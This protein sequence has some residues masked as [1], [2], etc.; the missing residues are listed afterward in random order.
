MHPFPISFH[1]KPS[2]Q[3]RS[4][5]S[6]LSWILATE[7]CMFD[8]TRTDAPGSSSG[9]FQWWCYWCRHIQPHPSGGP[10]MACRN[11]PCK[12]LKVET[13]PT[14]T[15]SVKHDAHQ[16]CYKN[17]DHLGGKCN[18][19][20]EFNRGKC[21]HLYIWGL[22]ICL[23]ICVEKFVQ[24]YIYMIWMAIVMYNMNVLGEVPLYLCFCHIVEMVHMCPYTC[25]T[26]TAWQSRGSEYL[27]RD[28]NNSNH[29]MQ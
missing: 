23:Y 17:N 5:A 11:A 21:G 25:A 1:I 27:L 2:E 8:T 24:L 28:R 26:F 10:H 3:D 7:V 22:W 14:S 15:S 18:I 9:P 16:W 12:T 20:M 4:V 19:K 13:C 6:K 29:K